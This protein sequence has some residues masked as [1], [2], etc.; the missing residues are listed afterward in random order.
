MSGGNM[1]GVFGQ[2]GSDERLSNDETIAFGYRDYPWETGRPFNLP[3]GVGPPTIGHFLMFNFDTVKRGRNVDNYVQV[4]AEYS[5]TGLLIPSSRL[6]S[7][8]AHGQSS[9][10]IEP[11]DIIDTGINSV[12]GIDRSEG[13]DS[14]PGFIGLQKI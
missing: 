4:E 5:A 10:S 14:S 2:E 3:N 13:D 1:Y 6:S 9:A 7:S 8:A 12:T 11:H